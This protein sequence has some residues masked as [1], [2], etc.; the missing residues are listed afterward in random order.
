MILSIV[1][2]MDVIRKLEHLNKSQFEKKL[3]K[4]TGYL[5]MLVKRESNP[6]ADVIAEF[7]RAFPDY[8]LVWLLTG[9]GNMRKDAEEA[10]KIGRNDQDTEIQKIRIDLKALSEGITKNFE[11]LS[12]AMMQSLLMQRK[13]LGFTDKLNAGDI[14]KATSHLEEILNKE[15]K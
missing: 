15:K 6:G 7:C 10:E 3:L 14:I 4:S 13:V 5:N 2:R 8:S 11:V 1:A 9:E 12:E